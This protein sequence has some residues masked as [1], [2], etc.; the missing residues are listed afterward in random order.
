MRKRYESW[1]EEEIEKKDLGVLQHALL[2]G[3]AETAE[4]EL[5][6]AAC[7]RRSAIWTAEKRFITDFCWEC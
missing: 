3:E 5:K 6:K 7:G 4:E 2:S 1:F